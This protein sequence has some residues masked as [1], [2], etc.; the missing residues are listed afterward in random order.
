M[1]KMK[2]WQSRVKYKKAVGQ[3]WN[4]LTQSQK[5]RQ[6]GQRR[7]NIWIYNGSEY[8]ESNKNN[9]PQMH[10]AHRHSIMINT[11]ENNLGISLSN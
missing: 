11:K 8:S 4:F 2:A 10:Q 7:K 1:A 9:R 6:Q 3:I 5:K